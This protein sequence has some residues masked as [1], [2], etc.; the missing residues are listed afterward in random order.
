MSDSHVR[1]ISASQAHLA[2]LPK[3]GFSFE[4]SVMRPITSVNEEYVN[5]KKYYAS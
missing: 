1:M 2:V 5:I 4:V 3:T